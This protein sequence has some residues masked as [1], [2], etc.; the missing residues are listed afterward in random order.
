MAGRAMQGVLSPRR[1][2]DL[3]AAGKHLSLT[4]AFRSRPPESRDLCG[5]HGRHGLRRVLCYTAAVQ[6]GCGHQPD[7]RVEGRLKSPGVPLHANEY[8]HEPAVLWR[9]KGQ[10]AKWSKI[11]LITHRCLK[12]ASFKP[13][14]CNGDNRSV[15]GYNQWNRLAGKS[16][17]DSKVISVGG[18]NRVLA[19]KL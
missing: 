4:S 12:K 14:Y 5:K 3:A 8:L 19:V 18:Y 7:R 11:D 15:S 2:L 6:P 1:Q 13:V 10:I 9:R 17:V 16:P